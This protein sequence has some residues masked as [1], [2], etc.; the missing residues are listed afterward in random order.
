MWSENRSKIIVRGLRKCSRHFDK[1]LN[2]DETTQRVTLFE[3]DKNR[4]GR[5]KLFIETAR[6]EWQVREQM[7][8]Q[9]E[10]M[11]LRDQLHRVS[12][13]STSAAP[14]L[15]AQVCMT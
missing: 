11:G 8:A 1:Q 4:R 15:R 6:E 2:G 14:S 5:V 12:K 7:L 9:S 10:H 13:L 3:D